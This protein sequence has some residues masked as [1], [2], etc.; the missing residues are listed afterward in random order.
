MAKATAVA[1]R[2]KIPMAVAATDLAM[3]CDAIDDGAEPSVA[4]VAMF[5]EKR[6]DLAASVDRRIMFITLIEAQ[7][8]AARQMRSSWDDQVQRLKALHETMRAKTKEII[9][10]APDLPYQGTLG[11]LSMQKNGGVAP[12]ATTW[13]DKELS[14]E[15]VEMFGVDERYYYVQ[16][17]YKLRPEVIVKDLE[18]GVPIE[19]A[20]L[21]PR[22]C[23]LRIKLT[24]EVAP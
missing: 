10:A 2:P 4:L 19:W 8:E 20:Q 22:G 24:P 3:L 14:Q 17:T 21:S 12:L 13:G 9:E 5:N 6:L 1:V 16:T 15:L 11:K 18:N 7:I 23:H